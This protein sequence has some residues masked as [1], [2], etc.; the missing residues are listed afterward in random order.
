M[1]ARV[2]LALL[3]AVILAFSSIAEHGIVHG[4][5]TD[6]GDYYDVTQFI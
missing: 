5:S 2:V 6:H 4:T 3:L 1:E